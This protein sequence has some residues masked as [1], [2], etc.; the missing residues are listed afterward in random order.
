MTTD[1][2]GTKLRGATQ[3]PHAALDGLGWVWVGYL[4]LLPQNGNGGEVTQKKNDR[5]GHIF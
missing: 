4:L 5:G 2:A 3:T 1:F